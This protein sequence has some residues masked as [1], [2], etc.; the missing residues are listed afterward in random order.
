M[1]PH[2]LQLPSALGAHGG[3]STTQSDDDSPLQ[4]FAGAG[5]GRD[6]KLMTLAALDELMQADQ[7]AG[8]GLG[9]RLDRGLTVRAW[10][11]IRISPLDR[12]HTAPPCLCCRGGR[13][14]AHQTAC[15]GAG[16]GCGR[17]GHTIIAAGACLKGRALNVSRACP[18]SL[19]S[20]PASATLCA[21][22]QARD[23]CA[24]TTAAQAVCITHGAWPVRAQLPAPAQ[25]SRAGGLAL[26]PQPWRGTAAYSQ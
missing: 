13:P 20:A 5:G 15:R 6:S 23:L 9:A 26:G 4:L 22:V 17:G 25:H 12:P 1:L 21:C 11:A 8:A 24:G 2:A 7:G 19:T 16:V 3:S 14:T 18:V 10:P